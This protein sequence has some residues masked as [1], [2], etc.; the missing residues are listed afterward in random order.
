M[1]GPSHSN[2]Q[3]DDEVRLFARARSGDDAAWEELFRR[4]YP[5][6]LRVIRRKLNHTMRPWYDSTDF[7]SDVMKSLAAKADR[8]DFQTPGSLMAFLRRV[9]EEKVIDEHRRVHRG[10]R[11]ISRTRS[12]GAF[13]ADPGESGIPALVADD[14]T[15][16][17]IVSAS[18]LSQRLLAG[19]EEPEQNVI[20]MRERG[21][22]VVE[23]SRETGWH[24]R[25]IQ[26]FIQELW[27]AVPVDSTIATTTE[28]ESATH[29]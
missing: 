2:A 4:C 26:R 1:T 15:A 9:A 3:G 18:E 24:P 20:R 12:L 16:S 23:I 13:G 8:L 5:K 17:E 6:L 22:S 10:K 7:A 28:P 27:T 21:Y 19:R 14:P 29:G 25:K 11:D